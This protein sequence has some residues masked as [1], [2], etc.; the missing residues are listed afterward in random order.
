[1]I[2]LILVDYKFQ[3]R[4]ILRSRSEHQIRQRPLS[5]DLAN[6]DEAFEMQPTKRWFESGSIASVNLGS[7]MKIFHEDE[8]ALNFRR[9]QSR[10]RIFDEKSF[11][12]RR[13]S[14]IKMNF[15]QRRATVA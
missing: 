12:G 4:V 1:M 2:C 8:K 15:M 14:L 6:N 9:S 13:S 10:I 3:P 11:L 7:S 5:M